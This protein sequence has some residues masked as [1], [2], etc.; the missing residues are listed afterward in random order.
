MVS[1]SSSAHSDGNPMP[2]LLR[3]I[4]AICSAAAT[5]PGHAG[6]AFLAPAAGA[7]S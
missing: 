1:I 4:A 2:T 7:Y 5:Y 3:A 6:R